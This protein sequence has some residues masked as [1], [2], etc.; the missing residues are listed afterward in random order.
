MLGSR[1]HLLPLAYRA[2]L[3]ALTLC[4]CILQLQFMSYDVCKSNTR[5]FHF[6]PQT[7]ASFLYLHSIPFYGY[8]ITY[9][10]HSQSH[11]IYLSFIFFPS[12]LSPSLSF[13]IILNNIVANNNIHEALGT[14]VAKGYNPSR[15]KA[16]SK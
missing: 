13:F 1:L 8:A 16:G 12:F 15:S 2:F 14:S 6:R 10:N 5:S 11:I 4:H 7:N 9:I 3:H